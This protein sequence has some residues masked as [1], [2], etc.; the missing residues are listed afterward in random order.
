VVLSLLGMVLVLS[1]VGCIA[2]L[3]WAG[4]EHAVIS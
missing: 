1:G 3:R 2:G 4:M